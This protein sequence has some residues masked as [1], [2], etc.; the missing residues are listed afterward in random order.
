MSSSQAN[1]D[2]PQYIE[3]IQSLLFAFVLAMVFRGFVVE[4]FVI[5]TGSMA[6]TLR[7]MHLQKQ[8][9]QTGQTF[10]VGFDNARAFSPDRFSDPLLGRRQSLGATE[11]KRLDP[12]MG[13]RVLV[14]KSLYSFFEPKRYDVVV[15]RNPTDTQGL[16]ANYIKRLIGLP[17]ETISIVDGDIFAKTDD[18]PFAIQRKPEHV[19]Q[20]LWR[21]VSDSDAIPIDTL[22]LSRPWRGQPWR[23]SPSS[24]WDVQDRSWRTNTTSRA[25]LEWDTSEIPVD[26]W[27]PYNMLMPAV[28]QHPTSDVNVS[29]TIVPDGDVLEASFELH[30]RGHTFTWTIKSNIVRLT[31]TRDNGEVVDA[32]EADSPVSVQAH[33]PIR[34][35]CWHVDQELVLFLNRKRVA[36]MAYDFGPDTRIRR[37]TNSLD[38]TPVEE[39]MSQDIVPPTFDWVFSG[40]PCSVSSI[41]VE[42][43]LY[44]RPSLLPSRATKNPTKPGNEELVQPGSPSYGTHIA[45]PAELGEDHYMLAGDNSAF[46]LD[47]RLWGNP[48]EFV[49]TQIDDTPFLVHR[50]LLIG[51]AWSVYWPAPKKVFGLPIVPDFSKVR[52]IR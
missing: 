50:D 30:S 33:I 25:T 22:A 2:Q 35:E 23:G 21:T 47:G 32:V 40:S 8:S 4:G 18:E 48:D 42:T 45:K 29:A 6:P 51:K 7:G 28:R 39:A 41:E 20:A 5:P 13:D 34:M 52:F 19:Q 36:S 26:D 10:A 49:A 3:T 14:L 46:S 27:V 31:M 38:S 24:A 1:S 37:A 16:A 15:F 43:D 9:P 44:Y 11:S 12:K 17:G